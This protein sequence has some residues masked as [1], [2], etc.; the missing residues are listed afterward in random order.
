MWFKVRGE[1]PDVHNKKSWLVSTGEHT[2]QQKY[3]LL[4]FVF[5]H[6]EQ[7]TIAA[8]TVTTNL[9]EAELGGSWCL[10]VQVK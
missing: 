8:L 9:G 7:M 6:T 10:N 3:L 2:R 5:M 1:E 4:V